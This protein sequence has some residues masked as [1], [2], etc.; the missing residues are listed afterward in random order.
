MNIE[1]RYT[2]DFEVSQLQELFLSV[3]WS[4]GQYP[5]VKRGQAAF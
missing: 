2:Q 1:Y 4:S 5:E 3:Q